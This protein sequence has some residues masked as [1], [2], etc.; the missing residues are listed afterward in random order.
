MAKLGLKIHIATYCSRLVFIAF[1]RNFS[2]LGDTFTD[3]RSS[4]SDHTLK[5][6]MLIRQYSN[7][8]R[9][10]NELNHEYSPVIISPI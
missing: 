9:F 7:S 4:T 10:F 2:V 8:K 1:E 5:T 3:K 6:L